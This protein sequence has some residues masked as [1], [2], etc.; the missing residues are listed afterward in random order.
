[1]GSHES[2][3]GAQPLIKRRWGDAL[4][5]SDAV[6]N[7]LPRREA[8][9]ERPEPQGA[10]GIHNDF[11][12]LEGAPLAGEIL[13]NFFARNR[14]TGWQILCA[15]HINSAASVSFRCTERR[16]SRSALTASGA[17]LLPSLAPIAAPQPSE[18][19]KKW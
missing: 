14:A 16:Q 8:R 9:G 10:P 17:R 6:L 19:S 1:M 2:L 18:G 11:Q 7:Y 5:G 15:P 3:E 13:L 4:N 12:A